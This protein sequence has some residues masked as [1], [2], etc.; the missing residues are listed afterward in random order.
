S[1]I[2]THIAYVGQQQLDGYDAIVHHA[3]KHKA[4]FDKRVL[5]QSPREV[6]FAPGQLTQFYH[7]S[8][9]NSLEAKRKLLPKWSIPCRVTER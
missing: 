9:H 2:S 3:I 6:I 4:A 5:V 7:S 8:I 1:D